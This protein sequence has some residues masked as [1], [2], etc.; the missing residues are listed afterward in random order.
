[1][2]IRVCIPSYRR[3]EV[4][5]LRYLPFAA[6]YVDNKDAETYRDL[7][8]EAEII[9]CPDGIQGNLCRVRNYLLREEFAHGADAVAILDDDY[10]GI[11]YWECNKTVH[12]VRSDEFLDFLARYSQ[13]ARE[14]G[15]FFWG[16]NVNPDP[17]C[18]RENTPFSTVSYIGGPFQVF[19]N[20]NECFYDERLPLKEDYDMTLQQLSRYRIALR[21]NKYFY[22]VKQSE[23]SGGCATYRNLEKE[24]E[25]LEMLRKKWGGKIIKTDSVDRSHK[26]KKSKEAVFI[27]YN[28]IIKAPI[29]GV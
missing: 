1:M 27:D 23:Q 19:L 28:P 2:K 7:N 4:M 22:R 25:Q 18:Y 20:G 14:W 26:G 5:T 6:V 21:L 24:R 9:V 17:Q 29:R 16:I 13:L 10:S 11:Y 3:P 15:A 8:P 12:P